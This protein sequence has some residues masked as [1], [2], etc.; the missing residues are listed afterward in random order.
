METEFRFPVR[1]MSEIRVSTAI[2]A[3]KHASGFPLNQ[4]RLVVEIV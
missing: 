4:F 3:D 2:G 1:S